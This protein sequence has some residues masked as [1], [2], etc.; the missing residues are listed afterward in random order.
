MK[1]KNKKDVRKRAEVAEPL[2]SQVANI[3]LSVVALVIL[4]F[5][6]VV[7]YMIFTSDTTAERN[8]EDYAKKIKDGMDVAHENP[9]TEVL[10]DLEGPGGNEWWII[11]WPYMDTFDKPKK[12]DNVRKSWCVCLCEIPTGFIDILKTIANKFVFQDAYKKSSLDLCNDGGRCENVYSPV[13][14]LYGD[15]K[16]PIPVD[17]VPIQ[18]KIKYIDSGTGYEIV[19]VK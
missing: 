17:E 1:K 7:V 3:I 18:I 12:C 6:G 10:I 14:T 13:K 11:A 16:A 4:I 8:A 5:A 9:G 2:G 15:L 19:F